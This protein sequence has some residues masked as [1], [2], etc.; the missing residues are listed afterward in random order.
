MNGLRPDKYRVLYG[1]GAIVMVMSLLWYIHYS[2][3]K[4]ITR[5]IDGIEK[6][7]CDED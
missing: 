6:C 4:V 7:Q 1:V 3:H 2:T 5:V